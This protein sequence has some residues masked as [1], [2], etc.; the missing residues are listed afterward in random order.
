MDPKFDFNK[1]DTETRALMCEEINAAEKSDN[2][3]FSTRFNETGK[4]CWIELLRKSAEE[5]N[6]H[7]LAD[8]L[9]IVGAMKV[10]ETKAKPKGGFTL[11]HVPEDATVTLADG[12]FNRFYMAAICRRALE[13]GKSSVM[14]Y[15][16]KQRMESRVESRQL[17]GTYREPNVLLHELRIK[18]LSFKCDLLKPNSG[19]SIDY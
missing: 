8:Q 10:T 7:W 12:Q 9:K 14:V 15:R 4:K 19:L 6:E 16:A 18:D 5:F 13:D 1:L 3:Y 17:E 2:I 11:A